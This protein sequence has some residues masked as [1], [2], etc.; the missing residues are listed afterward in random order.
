MKYTTS[1]NFFTCQVNL[2]YLYGPSEKMLL[3]ISLEDL[4]TQ[5]GKHYQF[6]S[7]RFYRE[8]LSEVKNK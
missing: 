6:I 7:V 8:D 5:V 1:S 2:L 3:I 4:F